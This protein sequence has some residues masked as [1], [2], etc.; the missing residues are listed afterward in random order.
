MSRVD[1]SIFLNLHIGDSALWDFILPKG[2]SFYDF[3]I[4]SRKLPSWSF[5]LSI[6]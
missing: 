2:K 6:M 1:I 4:G 3:S 5:D